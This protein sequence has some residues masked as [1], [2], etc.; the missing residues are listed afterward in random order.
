MAIARSPF[1]RLFLAGVFILIGGMGYYFGLSEAELTKALATEGVH[2]D[3]KVFSTY[4]KRGSK[5][6]TKYYMDVVFPVEAGGEGRVSKSIS[7]TDF[8]KRH[9]G[10]VVPLTYVKS[11]PTRTRLDTEGDASGIL[12]VVGAVF[13]AVGALV[14]L[15]PVLPLIFAMFVKG[16]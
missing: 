5:G 1:R 10:D 13:I 6:K 2:V 9:Q 7:S 4:T 16:G 14:L 11:D 12:K 8:G 3:G 15:W